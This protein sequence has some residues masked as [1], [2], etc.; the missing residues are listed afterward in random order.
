[1]IER[2]KYIVEK[3]NIDIEDDALRRICINANGDVRYPINKLQ[4]LSS[5]NRKIT[6]NDVKEVK[7]DKD[8]KLIVKTA[9]VDKDLKKSQELA[10]K[11]I[12]EKGIDER[13][14]LYLIFTVIKKVPEKYISKMKKYEV[15]KAIATADER[16]I[17]GANPIIQIDW[18]L[19]EVWK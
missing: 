11:Y 4:S 1:M 18:I 12:K 13:E 9:L 16:L 19:C 17:N 14:L 2:M 10:Y 7:V 15:I 6:A 8:I 5:L 3:E